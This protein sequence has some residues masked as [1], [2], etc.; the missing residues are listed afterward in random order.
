MVEIWNFGI[1][2]RNGV[3]VFLWVVII[4]L[5]QDQ[6]FFFNKFVSIWEAHSVGSLNK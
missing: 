2:C 3:E 6:I 4:V 1:E 5:V